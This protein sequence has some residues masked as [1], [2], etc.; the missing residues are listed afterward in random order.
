VE[1]SPG[2]RELTAS[3]CRVIRSLVES[4]C[5][6]YDRPRKEC[7]PLECACY[8]F[9]K[10]YTGAFYRYFENAVL[11]LNPLLVESLTGQAADTKT[12]P[13]CGGWFSPDG[14]RVYCSKKCRTEANRPKERERKKCLREQAAMSRDL[15]KKY[16]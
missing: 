16:Y 1:N 7:L 2:V 4:S 10:A 5:A 11:P 14:N 13:V 9:G 6:N 8:M 15:G 3:E 12:C